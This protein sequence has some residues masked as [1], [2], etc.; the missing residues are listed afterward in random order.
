F[1][2]LARF[3]QMQDPYFRAVTI[4]LIATFVG[5]QVNQSFN[6]DLPNNMFWFCIG[7]MFAVQR[8]DADLRSQPDSQPA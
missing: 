2:S 6:G 3:R 7:M 1:L 5:F 4:G 8:L